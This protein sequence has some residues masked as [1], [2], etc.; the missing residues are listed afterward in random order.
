[1]TRSK[2]IKTPYIFVTLRPAISLRFRSLPNFNFLDPSLT[3]KTYLKKK[4]K[5]FNS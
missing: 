3:G 2:M 5:L 1:M 4:K